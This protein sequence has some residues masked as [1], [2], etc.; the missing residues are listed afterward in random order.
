MKR[1]TLS[2]KAKQQ[3]PIETSTLVKR[4]IRNYL[5]SY[6]GTLWIALIFMIIAAAMTGAQAKLMEPIIDDVFM[7]EDKTRLWHVASFVFVV[8]LVR[9]FATYIH[10]VM[11]SKIGQRIIADV[12]KDMVGHL[13]HADLGYFHNQTSG[14]LISHVVSDAN[15]MRT[16]VAE[17]LTGIGKNLF[18]LIFLVIVMFYQDWKLSLIAITIFPLAG[19]AVSRLG[20][21]LRRASTAAQA[22]IADLSSLL[23]QS[24]MGIRHIKA[25]GMEGEEK[26]RINNIVERVFQLRYKVLRTS[27]LATPIS[28]TLAGLAI[29]TIILY[30]GIQVIEGVTTPGKLL[31]FITAFMMAYEPM[32]RLTKL[33]NVLQIGLA[34]AQR[35]FDLLDT[36]SQIVDQKDAKELK[37]EKPSVTIENVTFAY[38]DGTKALD[39]ISLDVASG[40]TVALVGASGS[41]KSTILNLIPRFYEAQEGKVLIDGHDVTEVTM[42]SLR[43]QM[44]L[45]SQEVALFNESIHDNIAYGSDDVSVEDVQTAAKNAAAYDFI[46]ELPDGFDTIV[47]EQGVKL[48]GGQRQ[49]IAI[50]RA[51]LRNAPIL[52]LD[53]ATSALD[54]QSERAVQEALDK[55]QQGRTTLVVAHRL[56]T[57]MHAD[58]IYVLDQGQVIEQ[59][60]HEDLLAQEGAYAQL[61][62]MNQFEG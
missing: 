46:M 30:G 43:S 9:G 61:Y 4:I 52:L 58:T 19:Y 55:L 39:Q 24:F 17:T 20:K 2:T 47:G 44:A 53:E 10:T 37:I 11:M 50:A 22:S 51:M 40:Q 8:F 27:A 16:A 12:Q 5:K 45:V 59:G 49:R 36:K 34:A 21:K 6:Q 29:V 35:V 54:T 32:K 25:Y 56:S 62:Q 26:S 42:A 60:K 33:N 14:G 41:G 15:V 23:N 7:G 18:T 3:D 57:I 28:E 13:V 38:P 31:S 48:S 1:L